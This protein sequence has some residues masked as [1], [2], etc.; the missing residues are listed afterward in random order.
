M[1]EKPF[2]YV[3]ISNAQLVATDVSEV[4]S[5]FGSALSLQ[6]ARE[7]CG[8][9]SLQFPG[10]KHDPRPLETITPVRSFIQALD[11]AIPYFP[12][13]LHP[14]PIL[15]EVLSY[16]LCLLPQTSLATVQQE[17]MMRVV[18]QKMSDVTVYAQKIG[19]DVDDVV[20]GLFLVM[21]PAILASAPS[22]ARQAMDTIRPMLLAIA[23]SATIHPRESA[24]LDWAQELTGLDR[25]LYGNKRDFAAA[26]LTWEPPI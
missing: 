10:L 26:L 21:P 7:M 16:V 20:I 11:K 14:D 3:E 13:F 6:S 2:R 24:Y 19:I 25:S 9:V 8:S 22:V 18:M 23:E 12:V 17:N 4:Q 5:L 1:S 15:G